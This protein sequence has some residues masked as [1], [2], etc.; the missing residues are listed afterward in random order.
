MPGQA[1]VT[2]M[3]I[4]TGSHALPECPHVIRG[5]FIQ[6]S[7]NVFTNALPTVRIGDM[8]VLDCPHHTIGVA[9]TGSPNVFTNGIPNHRLGD[10]DNFYCGIGV[11][12]TASP[13]VQVNTAGI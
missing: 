2:D 7:P 11:T 4:G 9:M 8:L 5:F 6:G 13:N 3:A 12:I 1:R 10:L